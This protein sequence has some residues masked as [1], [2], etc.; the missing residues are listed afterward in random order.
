MVI[1]VFVHF[2]LMSTLN[3]QQNSKRW[4][5]FQITASS[6]STSEVH[7]SVNGKQ[8]HS[9]HAHAHAA[10]SSGLHGKSHAHAHA[11]AFSITDGKLK[12]HGKGKLYVKKHIKIQILNIQ[13]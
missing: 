1:I 4:N 9:S 5:L 2:R 3:N 10:T 6:D 12:Y 13:L 8:V 11:S 7:V